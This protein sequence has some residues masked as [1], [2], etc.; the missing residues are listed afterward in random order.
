M[1]VETMSAEAAEKRREYKRNW[2]RAHPDKVRASQIKYWEKKAREAQEEHDAPL[3]EKLLVMIRAQLR[4]LNDLLAR[5]ADELT[6]EEKHENEV[7]IRFTES[8]LRHLMGIKLR[9]DG[10][11][12]PETFNQ[13]DV[14]ARA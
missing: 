12:T 5:Q 11:E 7:A 14:E 6:P 1:R 9:R 8:C 13:L 2:N 4:D 3:D 10:M